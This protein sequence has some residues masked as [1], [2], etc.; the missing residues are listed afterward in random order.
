MLTL[1]AS[2]IEAPEC[3]S[4]TLARP[5]SLQTSLGSKS[6][7]ATLHHQCQTGIDALLTL[8]LYR[9]KQ[10]LQQRLLVSPLTLINTLTGRSFCFSGWLL[11]TH[12]DFL[13]ACG[14]IVKL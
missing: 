7:F 14:A 13:A 6:V 9:G 4:L 8:F 1:S 10:Q 2:V 3:Q 5:Q 12:T 11:R